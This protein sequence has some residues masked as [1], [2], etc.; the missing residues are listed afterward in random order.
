MV[1]EVISEGFKLHV[2]I[3]S[4]SVAG[5]KMVI[6]LTGDGK[7]GSKSSTWTKLIPRLVEDGIEVVSFD[8][9]SLGDSEG[10]NAELSLSKGIKNFQDVV[11]ALD[12]D[13][14]RVGLVAA[15]FG[16]AVALNAVIR[17]IISPDY[18]VLKSAAYCLYEGYEHEQGSVQNM[19]V[20]Q[21]TGISPVTGQKYGIYLDSLRYG[22]YNEISKINCSTLVIHGTADT[23]IPFEQSIRLCSMNDHFELYP[24]EDVNHNYKQ[25]NALERFI[26]KT[27]DFIR[28]H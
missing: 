28:E 5:D 11:N 10:D 25:H 14:K 27:R 9:Y 15:S 13:R 3:D 20:W 16:G 7:A 23:T 21:S 4:P 22:D 2:E 24:L 17:G 8:F 1:K 19:Q 18:I 6:I 12:I 26:E